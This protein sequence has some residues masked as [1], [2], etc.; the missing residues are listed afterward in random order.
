MD[1]KEFM[2]CFQLSK[3]IVFEV[4]YFT[5]GDNKHPY[6]STSAAEFIRSK[7]DYSQCGQAQKEL[8]PKGSLARKFYDKWDHLHLK[9][10]TPEEYAEITADIE[11]LKTRY[12]YIEDIQDCFGGCAGCYYK[13][14][15]PFHEIVELSKLEP[16]KAVRRKTA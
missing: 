3:M 1:K 4:E 11:E 2:Y 8:L 10:L 12:N 9:D 6:F 13:T 16:K 15:I 14:H 5:L 7:R